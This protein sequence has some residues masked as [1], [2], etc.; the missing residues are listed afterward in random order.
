MR[1]KWFLVAGPAAI[2]ATVAVIATTL[3]VFI[4][5]FSGSVKIPAS[6][7]VCEPGCNPDTEICVNKTCVDISI[8]PVPNSKCHISGGE[9]CTSRTFAGCECPTCAAPVAVIYDLQG[10]YGQIGNKWNAFECP[11]R[12]HKWLGNHGC[13]LYHRDGRDIWKPGYFLAGW[14]DNGNA[15]PPGNDGYWFI[16]PCAGV[17]A[18][19]VRAMKAAWAECPVG[20]YSNKSTGSSCAP[21]KS[22]PGIGPGA[23]DC[24]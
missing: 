6:T 15:L 4:T 9:I 2:A 17:D 11:S 8:P 22:N 1:N 18:W 5:G 13:A 10:G 21:C 20:T 16:K 3:T 14:F 24:K 7:R 19:T 12:R 23:T